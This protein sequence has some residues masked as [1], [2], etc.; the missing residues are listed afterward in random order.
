MPTDSDLWKQRYPPW[1]AFWT[2]SQ[3][4]QA[5][6]VRPQHQRRRHLES[7]PRGTRQ[8]QT[9]EDNLAFDDDPDWIRLIK[10]GSGKLVKIEFK[11]P[12]AVK[13]IGFKPIPVARIGVYADERR[14]S[15]PVENPV[16][17][18]TMPK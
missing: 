8:Y 11:D 13:K 7:H 4:P 14:T 18:V 3:H 5:Q 1:P 16:R 15:W 9:I 10:D 6:R 2:T 12:A 17:V